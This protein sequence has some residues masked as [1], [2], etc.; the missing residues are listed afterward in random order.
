MSE[1]WKLLLISYYDIIHFALIAY[2]GISYYDI[3]LLFLIII[4]EI[5]FLL[6]A[7]IN[8]V[9]Y[10]IVAYPLQHIGY[11]QRSRRRLF[12]AQRQARASPQTKQP[13]REVPELRRTVYEQ[14]FSLEQGR[15]SSQF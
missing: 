6:S 4:S 14:P 15:S 9:G 1:F 12:L 3:L 7:M 5:F 2:Y 13:A 10:I 8:R 11:V